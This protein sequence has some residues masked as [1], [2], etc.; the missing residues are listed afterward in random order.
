M[1]PVHKNV[2]NRTRADL[3]DNILPDELG[4]Q[5]LQN[6]AITMKDLERIR[7]KTTRMGQTEEILDIIIRKP[8]RSYGVFVQCLVDTAQGHIAT[9]LNASKLKCIHIYN[10]N[11]I[12][13]VRVVCRQPKSEDTGQNS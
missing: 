13:N 12:H 11:N 9:L 2:L 4:S 5:L 10:N 8:D 3:V 6:N 7:A 1:S